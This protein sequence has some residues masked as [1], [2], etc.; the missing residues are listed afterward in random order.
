MHN[1]QHC[2][3]NTLAVNLN[4]K[5]R[6]LSLLNASFTATLASWCMHAGRHTSLIR[7]SNSLSLM[8]FLMSSTDLTQGLANTH[9]LYP[10][11]NMSLC[12][13]DFLMV[14]TVLATNCFLLMFLGWCCPLLLYLSSIVLPWRFNW[15]SRCWCPNRDLHEYQHPWRKWW[16]YFTWG[17]CKLTDYLGQ[18]L[19][20]TRIYDRISDL[21]GV[22]CSSWCCTRMQEAVV[23]MLSSCL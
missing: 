17:T 5:G 10:M 16:R 22:C 9:F 4:M 23:L 2:L 14:L 12:C 13:L 15:S 1:A 8:L 6:V 18:Q 7:W 21:E 19:Q 3:H 20:H 11:C